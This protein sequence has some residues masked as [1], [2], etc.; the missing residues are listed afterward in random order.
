[1]A[2]YKE[3]ADSILRDQMA[4][5]EQID[6]IIN[7]VNSNVITLEL[8]AQ[9]RNTSREGFI[10]LSKHNFYSV[11]E[12]VASNQFCPIDIREN[13][14]EDAHYKVRM[15]ANESLKVSSGLEVFKRKEY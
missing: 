8:A 3:N 15:A 13:L 12:K 4:S 11:R 1:M 6:R 7:D 2:R 9:H 5:A 14:V 10:V